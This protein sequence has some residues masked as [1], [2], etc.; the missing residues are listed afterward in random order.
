MEKNWLIRTKSNHIL[1][2]ISKEKLQE[3]YRN[4]SVKPDD[5]VCSG[6]G[7]WFFIREN[8]LV[9]RFLLGSEM[10]SFN[11]VSEAKDV[12]NKPEVPEEHAQTQE[13]SPDITVVSGIKVPSLENVNEENQS[14]DQATK[15][16]EL[17]PAE[18]SLDSLLKKNQ[19][20]KKNAS[21]SSSLIKKEPTPRLKK[22]GFLKWVGLIGFIILFCLIY[23]RKR[24][25]KSLFEEE[26]A[27][28]NLSPITIAFAEEDNQKKKI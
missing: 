26:S 17:P 28:I 16:P 23:F 27:F 22:Q 25:I 9:E 4:G 1:G 5:E 8:D 6:N 18:I 15:E 3:L 11:P 24:I 2:P 7:F 20:D 19:K 12:I 21:L 10:Q 13:N 14:N